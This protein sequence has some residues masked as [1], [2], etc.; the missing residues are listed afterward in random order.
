LVAYVTES[1]HG[2]SRIG[3]EA[4]MDARHDETSD[5]PAGR[6][7]DEPSQ[8]TI[9][10]LAREFGLTLRT[11]RFYEDRGLLRPER[12]GSTRLYTP[13][14]RRRLKLILQARRMGFTL[15]EIYGILADQDALVAG[16]ELKLAPDQVR[17]Q[18][19][20]L[21]QQR[22]ALETAIAELRQLEL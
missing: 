4:M 3:R 19:D 12:Q 15:R 1:V 2:I 17:V 20:E 22:Y 10:A 16:P 5:R 7:A 6:V 14:D 21:E 8:W 9:G 11:L 13:S 18:I